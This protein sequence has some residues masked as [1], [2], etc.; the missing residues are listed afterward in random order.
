M[1][2]TKQAPESNVTPE[3]D[4]EHDNIPV[5]EDEHREA[6]PRLGDEIKDIQWPAIQ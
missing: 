5:F 6:N 4:P 3:L 1:T 2:K